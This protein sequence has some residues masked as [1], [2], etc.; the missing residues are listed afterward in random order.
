MSGVDAETEQS[1]VQTAKN[2]TSAKLTQLK[3]TIILYRTKLP[4]KELKQNNRKQLAPGTVEVQVTLYY[5]LYQVD[6]QTRDAIKKELKD[7][8]KDNEVELNKL[9]GL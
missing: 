4:R 3:P 6:F 8:L 7:K 9:M 1:I 2:I 5:D